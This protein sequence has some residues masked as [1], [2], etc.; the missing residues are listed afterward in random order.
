MSYKI[1][2]IGEIVGKYGVYSARK[3]IKKLKSDYDIDFV[4]ANANGA[5]GGYGLGKN[6]AITLKNSGI[7]VLT[8]GECVFFKKDLVEFLP[9][10]NYTLRPANYT[11]KTPG[12]GY[13]IYT[14]NNKKIAIINLLGPSGIIK[15]HPSNPFTYVEGLIDKVKENTDIII[16]N[17]HSKTTAEKILM[18][19]IVNGKCNALI[20]SGSKSLTAD[21]TISKEKTAY[22]TDSGRTGSS[23]APGGLSGDIE[24][25]KFITGIPKRSKDINKDLELQGVLLTF[26]DN[27]KVENIE[28]LRVPI[29]KEENE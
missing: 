1:L 2:F 20:G 15:N 21:A 9:K 24:I 10:C 11:P 26:N 16:I 28:T 5:T 17:F 7:D 29:K 4:I 23:T 19:H 14:H 18:F 6:H 12:K 22:I 27:N 25:E 13:S 3:G 8:N